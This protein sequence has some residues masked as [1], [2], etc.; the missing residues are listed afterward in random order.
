MIEF[1]TLLTGLLA[2]LHTV[3]LGAAAEVVTVELYLDGEMIQKIESPPW[4]VEVDFGESLEAHRLEARGLDRQGRIM[5]RTM[6]HINYFLT[7]TGALLVPETN[8]WPPHRIRLEQWSLP[9]SSPYRRRVRLD[10]VSLKLGEDGR[11]LLSKEEEGLLGD[12]RELTASVAFR[13]G[14]RSRVR[15]ALKPGEESLPTASASTRI[16]VEPFP[17]S[18][19]G[20]SKPVEGGSRFLHGGKPLAGLEMKP[21]PPVLVIVRDPN[22]PARLP[23]PGRRVRGPNLPGS[24]KAELWLVALSPPCAG[25]EKCDL[26][27]WI[28]DLGDVRLHTGLKKALWGLPRR[29]LPDGSLHFFTAAAHGGRLASASGRPR[30][31]LLLLDIESLDASDFDL[32]ETAAYLRSLRVPFFVWLRGWAEE[33]PEIPAYLSGDLPGVLK[34]VVASLERQRIVQFDGELLPREIELRE[35]SGLRWATTGESGESTSK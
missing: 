26:W 11:I 31:V 9:R 16:A 8:A 22:L 24:S 6:H 35:G 7:P 5:G 34:E 17:A 30:A 28:S 13:G 10:G 33:F 29:N 2:G 14:G 4:T 21:E 15:L 19:A 27:F 3:E 20:A 25:P 18:E 23:I 32:E 1:V 12:A